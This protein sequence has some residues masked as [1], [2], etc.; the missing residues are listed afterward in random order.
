MLH[1][2]AKD[3]QS[4]GTAEEFWRCF[5]KDGHGGHVTKT[6]WTNFSSPILTDWVGGNRKCNQQSTNPDQNI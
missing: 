6:I 2:K 1:T 4:S 5:T 3:H